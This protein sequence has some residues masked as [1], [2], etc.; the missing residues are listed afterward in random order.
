MLLVDEADALFGKPGRGSLTR[1]AP[2]T[3]VK[4]AAEVVTD[5][6]INRGN[7]RWCAI[8]L[9]ELWGWPYVNL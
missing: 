7:A 1:L 4:A 6:L 8:E 9:A 5:E 3:F 2:N